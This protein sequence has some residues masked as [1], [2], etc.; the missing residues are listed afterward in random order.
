[1]AVIEITSNCKWKVANWVYQ[2]VMDEV[3]PSLPADSD[4]AK[5]I[6]ETV[7]SNI[8]SLSFSDLPLNALQ[9]FHAALRQGFE[10]SMSKG[11]SAFSQPEFFPSFIEQFKDL[12]R[13]VDQNQRNKQ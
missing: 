8:L 2:A 9:T 3:L 13:M 12:V 5:E 10:D 7:D 6:K 11:E 4:L 1:M